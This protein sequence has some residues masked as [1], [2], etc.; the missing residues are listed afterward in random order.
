M[1]MKSS[2]TAADTFPIKLLLNRSVKRLVPVHV[3][4]IPT[5]R[6][7]MRCTVCCCS[8]RDRDLEMDLTIAQAVIQDLAGIGCE[9]VT[10][11]GGGEPLCHP[12]IQEMLSAFDLHDVEVGLVTNGMLLDRL[13]E[14][15]LATLTWCRISN[16]DDRKFSVAY[17]RTLEDAVTRGPKVDWAFSHVVSSQPNLQEIARIV[18]FANEHHFTH[19][20]LVADI[21][22][23][24]DVDMGPVREYLTGIDQLVIYQ[25]RNTPV[26]SSGC[27]IG[28][29]KPVIA[30]DFKMYHCCGVQYALDPP[31]MDFPQELC[32]GDA[33]HLSDLYAEKRKMFKVH[34]ARCYY[35]SYNSVL[36]PLVGEIKHQ[37]FL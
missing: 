17:R 32:M 33:R 14:N 23:A 19:V 16:T 8:A 28:Y 36:R 21:L 2:Y 13:D 7:N 35:E 25:P 20:R 27:V 10:I 22:H 24:R 9:A 3:Q 26:P 37:K 18:E 5:N 34:C 29:V 4:W 30:P 31:S 15:D 1:E 12:H 6:C 11:T